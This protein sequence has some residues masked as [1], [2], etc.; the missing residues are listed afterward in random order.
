MTGESS[1]P[2]H[3][4]SRLA[5][6]P[7][8][9]RAH[10]Q[11]FAATILQRAAH[12]VLLPRRSSPRIFRQHSTDLFVISLGNLSLLMRKGDILH[13]RL[14]FILEKKK[15][16][17]VDEKF[18]AGQEI[19][20]GLFSVFCSAKSTSFLVNVESSQLFGKRAPMR[21]LV[22][23]VKLACDKNSPFCDSCTSIFPRFH[24]FLP[25][26][27]KQS[28]LLVDGLVFAVLR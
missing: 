14:R 26:G 28:R 27:M 25:W 11:L 13:R 5:F 7:R 24:R 17:R 22:I 1:Q 4:R 10:V 8:R 16:K 20:R 21:V 2:L 3:S 19:K 23:A 18:S 9:V 6:V 12:R 15:K